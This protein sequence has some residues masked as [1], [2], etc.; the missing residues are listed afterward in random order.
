MQSRKQNFITSAIFQNVFLITWILCIRLLEKFCCMYS[1]L[2][3]FSGWQ[4]FNLCL[5][6]FRST[7]YLDS[8]LYAYTHSQKIGTMKIEM[9]VWLS[10]SFQMTLGRREKIHFCH[11][12]FFEHIFCILEYLVWCPRNYLP[13]YLNF[14]HEEYLYLQIIYLSFLIGENDGNENELNEM[15]SIFQYNKILI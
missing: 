11:Q 3:H 2:T 13:C 14:Y 4:W 1:A 7:I 9:M 10:H 8:K 6:H 15:S 5:W 12:I